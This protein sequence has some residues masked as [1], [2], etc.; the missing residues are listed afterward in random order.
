MEQVE[1]SRHRSRDLLQVAAAV[2]VGIL[3][4]GEVVLLV[5]VFQQHRSRRMEV[6]SSDLVM[7]T[8]P[9]AV[10]NQPATAISTA[11]VPRASSTNAPAQPVLNPALKI[12]GTQHTRTPQAMTVELRL[13]AQTGE[14]ELDARAVRV[15]VEWLRADGTKQLEWLATPVSWENFAAKTLQARYDG[16]AAQVRGYTVRTFYRQQ[17]QDMTTAEISNP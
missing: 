9:V 2:C 15:S 16:A 8:P 7:V 6:Q 3:I 12:Q 11:M 10:T 1:S 4:V 5:R 13:R 14:R 17:L